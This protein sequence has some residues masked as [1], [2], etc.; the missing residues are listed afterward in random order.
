MEDLTGYQIKGYELREQIGVGGYGAVYRAHQAQIQR[1]VAIKIILPQYANHPDFIR[2][3]EAEAHLVARLEHPHIVP[4]YDYWREPDGA[5]LVMRWLRGG[6]LHNLLTGTPWKIERLLQILDEIGAALT[7]AHRH[8]V[9]HR[10]LKP[11]NILLD[12]DGN[13][14]LA[15]FG[16]AKDLGNVYQTDHTAVMGSPAYISP[17]Q[18]KA[19]QISPQTDIYSLGVMIYEILTGAL[20]FESPTP[21]ALLF[22]H[23]HEPMPPLQTLRPDLPESVNTVIQRATAKNPADRY[24]DVLR[25]VIELRHALGSTSPER[26]RS[27][28]RTTPTVVDGRPRDGQDTTGGRSAYET[29]VINRTALLEAIAPA[30]ENPYKGLRAFQEADASDFFGRE[31]LTGHLLARM[32]EKSEFERFLAVVGP[33]GGGK[34]SV[35]RAGLIPAL[36]RGALPGSQRWFVVEMIPGTNPLQELESALL[37]VA[38]N[39]PANLLERLR[40]DDQ[41]LLHAVQRLLP[42][43]AETELVLVIDQFEEVFTLLEDEAARTHFL[44]SLRAAVTDPRSRLRL[45][46]TL[47]ADFYDRPLLYSSLS[48]MVRQR[49]EVVV[50]LAPEELQ[51]AIAGPARRVGLFLEPDLVAAIIH[52]VGEQPG[53]LPLLQYALTELFERRKGRTL[54]LEAYHASGGVLGALARRADEIY[55]ELNAAEQEAARQLFLRLVTL[56]EGTEDTRR[57][58]HLSEIGDWRSEIGDFLRN[59]RSPISNLDSDRRL[60][61]VPA[62]DT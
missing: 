9:V 40:E 16:I 29:V 43:G 57:R 31:A 47:R 14:Y 6:S 53:A 3:F 45:I 4:L 21:I 46:I 10:D 23:I 11:A 59:L 38:V 32:A 34:S 61:Q 15:D 25:M 54:T 26:A 24:P 41:G 33:S 18:I 58:V 48:E 22:K 1:E 50:P 28:G 39:R 2:R 35:V 5:Y 36:R 20:P 44:N 12:E 60:Q 42:G 19:E 62:A 17:E 8:G 55:T 51:H 13:A 27:V 56:G 30:V 37:R 52:D 7:V 49:T